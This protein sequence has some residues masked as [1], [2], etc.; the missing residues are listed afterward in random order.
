MD[1]DDRGITITANVWLNAFKMMQK[2][3]MISKQLRLR[4]IVLFCFR[5]DV[6]RDVECPLDRE[7]IRNI[8]RMVRLTPGTEKMIENLSDVRNPKPSEVK[9]WIKRNEDVAM[10]L[11]SLTENY[12][13]MMLLKGGREYIDL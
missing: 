8:V 11:E 10:D 6:E 3:K 4:H 13:E 12:L 7:L 9:F 1:K 2:R 5:I